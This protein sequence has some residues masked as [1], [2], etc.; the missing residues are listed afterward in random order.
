[1]TDLDHFSG[2]EDVLYAPECS[3]STFLYDQPVTGSR[4]PELT[5]G[6]PQYS[7]T[8]PVE[9][10]SGGQISFLVTNIGQG[11]LTGSVTAEYPFSVEGEDTFN[12]LSAISI[13][14][15]WILCFSCHLRNL[16]T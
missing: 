14:S 12:R 3:D 1:M 10:G 6:L 7:F 2:T 11:T 15:H 8:D 4:L 16:E 13:V 5:V 9:V